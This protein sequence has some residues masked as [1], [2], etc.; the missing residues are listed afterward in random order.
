[1]T[2]AT[3][4][5][6][7]MRMQAIG[8][9]GNVGLLGTYSNHGVVLYTNGTERMRI[10]SAGRVG[11]GGAPATGQTLGVLKNAVGD[12]FGNGAS[13]RIVNTAESSG[14]N[15][16]SGVQTGLSTQAASYTLNNLHHY[17]ALQGT[18]G[19]GSTV[20]NQYGF[21][22]S[23]NLTGA[24]NNYGFYSNIASGTGRYNFYAAGSATNY[25]AGAISCGSYV[26]AAGVIN[27]ASL[28]AVP[29]GGNTNVG[30][31][32]TT[33]SNFGVFFGSGAPTLSAAKGSLYLRSDGSTTNNRMYVNTDGATTWTAVTTAA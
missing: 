21:D 15:N 1:M 19:A 14:T 31:T 3:T 25:F 4:N 17:W 20:T 24:T 18:F 23:A 12:S 7:D 5:G 30:Y 28:T 8:A 2:R 10:D 11:I 33:T 13:I 22:V 9:A 32:C 6:V 29:A 26:S 16:I 27:G